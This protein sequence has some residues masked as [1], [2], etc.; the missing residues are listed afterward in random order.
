MVRRQKD[1]Y[2][3]GIASFKLGCIGFGGIAGMVSLIESEIVAK[4]GW[5]TRDHFLDAVGAA[6]II[7][8]PNSVEIIM[9]CAREKGGRAGLV[10]GGIMYILPAMLICLLWAYLYTQYGHLPSVEPFL[11]GIRPATAAIIAGAVFRLSKGLFKRRDITVL[12]L[13]VFIGALCGL[14]D[15]ALLFGAGL[16]GTVSIN[17]KQMRAWFPFPLLFVDSSSGKLFFIFFKIGAILYGSGYV[18]F[19]Y[20]DEALVQQNHW[21]TRQQLTDAI[22]VGQITP[23]PILSSATFAG[24]LISGVWGG[25]LATIAIFLPS[26]FIAFFVHRLL[27]FINRHVLLRKFLNIVNAASV[28]LIAAVAIQMAGV[29]MG[30]WQSMVILVMSLALVLLTKVNPVWLIALG[31]CVGYLLSLM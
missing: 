13:L 18:L 15:V 8:G 1:L 23:G 3:I 17:G 26:F 12:S 28:A 7:P 22:S 20:M 9:H 27:A 2:E 5:I 14:N 4:R 30:Q 19:A 6:N 10:V 16:A 24:Y 31:S 29:F 11:Y 25:V 21:L